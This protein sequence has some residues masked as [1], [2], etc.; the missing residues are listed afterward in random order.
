MLQVAGGTL[1]AEPV[2]PIGIARIS[3]H[4]PLAGDLRVVAARNGEAIDLMVQDGSRAV[5][6]IRQMQV[7]RLSD[8]LPPTV[9][10]LEW[11][12]AAATSRLASALGSSR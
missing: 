3:L 4:A 5:A 2:L 8:S 9:A 12:S 10:T 1:P 6:N 7:R 11:Q